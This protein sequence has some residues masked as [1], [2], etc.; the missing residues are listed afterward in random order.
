MDKY[1][2]IEDFEQ[3]NSIMKSNQLYYSKF[4]N[5]TSKL[6]RRSIYR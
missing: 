1:G 3:L 4:I 5:M 6:M 2:I